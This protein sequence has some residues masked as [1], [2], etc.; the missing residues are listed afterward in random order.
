[1]FSS[2]VY[3]QEIQIFEKL[4]NNKIKFYFDESGEICSLKEAFYYRV[5][6]IDTNT[7]SF[8]GKTVDYYKNGEKSY[9]CNFNY[10]KVHGDV[11]SFY[12]NGNIKYKGI[13]NKGTRDSIWTFYY[14]NGAIEKVLQYKMGELFIKERYSKN[15]KP[16]IKDGNGKYS[17][18][19]YTGKRPIISK[20]HGKIVNGKQDGKWYIQSIKKTAARPKPAFFNNGILVEGYYDVESVIGY[21]INENIDIFRFISSHE[22]NLPLKFSQMIKYKGSIKISEHFIPE[23]KQCISTFSKQINANNFLCLISFEISEN[24]LIENVSIFSTLH[25]II[26]PISN[27]LNENTSFETIKPNNKPKRSI[28]Y[29]PIIKI[30]DEILIPE[31]EG[32]SIVNIMPFVPE[33]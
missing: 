30:N 26:E 23:I 14:K 18:Y 19:I 27:Y 8:N 3:G 6:T 11:Y 4:P 13:F 31:Y 17:G 7:L 32:S 28:V 9:E 25:K 24:N 20:I 1:M 10:G 2:L 33:T 16:I 22:K 15:G 5:T 29:L 21:I 12:K